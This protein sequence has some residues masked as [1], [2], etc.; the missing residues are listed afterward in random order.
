MNTVKSAI[1]TFSSFGDKNVSTSQKVLNVLNTIN[2]AYL[3]YNS[4]SATMN[5]FKI[6]NY[7]N[8]QVKAENLTTSNKA[9][10]IGKN[11]EEYISKEEGIEKNTTTKFINSRDRIIDFKKTVDGN[12][13]YIESK[14]VSSLSYTKQI[15]DFVDMAKN[16]NSANYLEL[17]VR[18]TTK[19][20]QPLQNAIDCGD[21]VLKYLPC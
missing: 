20:S 19:L 2:N 17:Y 12:T 13:R 9:N 15:R 7:A 16:D 10:A 6:Y 11:A 4:A 1:D 8:N 3:T 14:N 21:I 5:S 18:P